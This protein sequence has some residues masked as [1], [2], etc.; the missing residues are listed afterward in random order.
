VKTHKV[1]AT[2]KQLHATS[3]RKVGKQLHRTANIMMWGA[4]IILGMF[5]AELVRQVGPGIKPEPFNP[6]EQANRVHPW[7][8]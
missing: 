1:A 2:Q 7:T 4:D 8:H 5:Q 6:R 3:W